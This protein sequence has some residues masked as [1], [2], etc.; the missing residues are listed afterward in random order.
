MATPS[1]PPATA[2]LSRASGEREE[3][4]VVPFGCKF[5]PNLENSPSLFLGG[6]RFENSKCAPTLKLI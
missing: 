3:G 4:N 5:F 1:G 6:F 2:Q